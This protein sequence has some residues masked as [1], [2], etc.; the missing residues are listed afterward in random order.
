[1]REVEASAKEREDAIQKALNELGIEMSDVKDIEIVEEG[2]RGLFG[3]GARPWRVKVS[4]E[5]G[6][7]PK[8]ERQRPERGKRGRGKREDRTEGKAR[9][10]PQE[11]KE[12]Q[13]RPKSEARGER[14]GRGARGKGRGE[15][16]RQDRGGNDGGRRGGNRRDNRRKENRP[17]KRGNGGA[18]RARQEPRSN[19]AER[20]KENR[21]RK[22]VV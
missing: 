5:G 13:D 3:L 15:G 17:E 9:P 16:G 7:P 6:A 12:K 18:E 1:M 19:K 4:A 14:K 20:A 21:D 22:S 2:S 11:E 10:K 8:R